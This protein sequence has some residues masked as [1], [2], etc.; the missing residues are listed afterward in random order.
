MGI[1]VDALTGYLSGAKSLNAPPRLITPAVPD[2][3]MPPKNSNINAIAYAL[4]SFGRGISPEG[5]FG[6]KV[7]K[8]AQDQVRSNQFAKLL[9]KAMGPDDSTMTINNKGFT[10]KSAIDAMMGDDDESGLG[11]LANFPSGPQDKGLNFNASDL[12]G[13][14]PEDIET[15]ARYQKASE[16][17]PFDQMKDMINIKYQ[18][19]LIDQMQFNQEAKFIELFTKD[20]RSELMKNFEALNESRISSGMNPLSFSDYFMATKND[21]LLQ[22]QKYKDEGGDLSFTDWYRDMKKAGA[23]VIDMGDVFGKAKAGAEGR[24]EAY[25]K[26]PNYIADVEKRAR[27]KIKF[28]MD[29][30]LDWMNTE[31]GEEPVPIEDR[32]KARTIIDIRSDLQN[33]Y[34]EDSIYEKPDKKNRKIRWYDTRTLPHTLI[35][36]YSF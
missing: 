7:G 15:I 29:N 32:V 31:P 12:V 4:A 2:I 21:A 25:I 34:G 23:S 16:Q 22:Y 33:R 35:M 19:G 5:S 1:N 24:D 30:S 27:D 26:S 8:T 36:S 3:N 17:E 10:F 28:E 14:L 9:Q 13:L 18:L 20:D 11:N 6:D